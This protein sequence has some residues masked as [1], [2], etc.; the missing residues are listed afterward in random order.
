[1][2]DAADMNE[3]AAEAALQRYEAEAAAH[4]LTTKQRDAAYAALD[5]VAEW[6]S[7]AAKDDGTVYASQYEAADRL[8]ALLLKHGVHP[9]NSDKPGQAEYVEYVQMAL[10][11][12]VRPHTYDGY[13]EACRVWNLKNK[14]TKP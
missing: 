10:A 12:G 9:C 8:N 14:Q 3:R 2:Q 6:A 13:V 4:D 7:D 1:M 5:A 11:Q